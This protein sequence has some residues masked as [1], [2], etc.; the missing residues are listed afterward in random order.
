MSGYP[1]G[2]NVGDTTFVI[3]VTDGKGGSVSQVCTLKVVHTNHAPKFTCTT[4]TNAQEDNIFNNIVHATDQDS[5]LFGDRIKYRF[6]SNPKWLQLDTISG[7]VY[8]TPHIA[9]LSDSIVAIQ[10]N[11]NNGGTVTQQFNIH[12][13]H[14]NHKPVLLTEGPFTANE[15]SAFSYSVNAVDVDT[16]IGDVL[17][18]RLSAKSQWMQIDSVKGYISGTPRGVNVGKSLFN[19]TVD[20]GHGGI[21]TKEYEL[22]VVHINHAPSLTSS[23][24]PIALED[25]LYQTKIVANDQD[26]KLFNDRLTYH[27]SS[28]PWLTIDSITGIITGIP[29]GMNVQR[30]NFDVTVRDGRGGSASYTYFVNVVHQNHSPRILSSPRS[31]AQEDSTYYYAPIV[32]DP[33]TLYGDIARF[34]LTTRPLWLN[35]DSIS[36]IVSGIPKAVNVGD[37]IAVLTVKDGKGGAVVQKFSLTVKHTNHSPVI[38]TSVLPAAIEDSIYHVTIA[39]SDP[40]VNRYDDKLIFRVSTNQWLKIDSTSGLLTGTPNGINAQNTE[41]SILVLDGEGGLTSHNYSVS[42]THQNHPPL[43]VSTPDTSV[44][45]DS[46]YIYQPVV[47]DPDTKVFYDTVKDSVMII[48]QFLSTNGTSGVIQGIPRADYFVGGKDKIKTG[49]EGYYIDTVVVLMAKDNRGGTT[50]QR[51]NLRVIH[52]NHQPRFVSMAD[53]IA[54][55]D[56]VYRYAIQGY[57]IDQHVFGDSLRYSVKIKPQWLSLNSTTNILSGRP[58]SENVQDTLVVIELADGIGGYARQTYNLHVTPTNHPPSIKSTPESVA[59]EDSTYKYSIIVEDI[60]K[61]FKHDSVTIRLLNGPVWLSLSTSGE[62]LSGK[63][64]VNNIGDTVVRIEARD[65]Y[66]AAIIQEWHI[67]VNPVKYVP[68]ASRLLYPRSTDTIAAHIN[69]VEVQFAWDKASDRN[70]NDVLL[71]QLHVWSA[72]ND[73]ITPWQKDTTLSLGWVGGREF[74]WSVIVTDGYFTVAMKDTFKVTI[75]STTTGIATLSSQIPEQFIAYQN[76]PNPFNPSTIIRFGI[77]ERSNVSL[78]IY[79]SIGQLV[80]NL[81]NN[82]NLDASYY[83]VK[84]NAANCANGVYFSVLRAETITSS[85]RVYRSVKKLLLI[86]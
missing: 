80:E 64:S 76:Y 78:Q 46:L 68:Q 25:S 48:P 37:T 42:V 63:P 73:T 56:S 40:D 18:F 71:Y 43:Y 51:F 30:T 12:V 84:W 49:K 20:D 32:V 9:D 10:A 52:Q 53:T 36:G 21:V 11:D 77:P 59:Y 86:K 28:N 85:Q 60:D 14:T 34:S 69:S 15:D 67:K 38:I 44:F 2:S 61:T 17:R 19:V 82:I 57:D 58:L 55:E 50:V 27:I 6:I 5:L 13:I 3:K 66:A 45:E 26:E 75:Q 65:K 4:L 1:R 24:L 22:D 8:G 35:I 54:I 41:I 74:R 70:Y 33:D 16:I 23:E 72:L 79:N 39:A 83:E 47:M 7:R 29:N 31:N 81:Y 62:I